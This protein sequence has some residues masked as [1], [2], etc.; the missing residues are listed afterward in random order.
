MFRAFG[1]NFLNKTE[2]EDL[3]Y[4]LLGA[5]SETILDC[6]GTPEELRLSLSLVCNKTAYKNAYLVQKAVEKNILITQPEEALS[7]A[8]ALS[9]DHALPSDI[10]QRVTKLLEE[11]LL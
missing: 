2:L 8:L 1:R 3:F 11:K 10:A 7:G 9:D 4:N 5:G 6:V